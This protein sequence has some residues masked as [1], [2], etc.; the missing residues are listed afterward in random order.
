MEEKI[1]NCSNRERKKVFI[2]EKKGEKD[3]KM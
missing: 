3:E 1:K 2:K